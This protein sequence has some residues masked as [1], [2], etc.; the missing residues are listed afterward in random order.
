MDAVN[1]K[2]VKAQKRI[3]TAEASAWIVRLHGPYRTPELEEGFRAWLSAS[4]ENARQFERVT[5][6]WEAAAVPV[7]GTPRMSHDPDQFQPRRWLLAAAVALVAVGAGSWSANTLWL[8]P[9]YTT[10]IGEQRIFPLS[11]GS[12]VT[13]NSGSGVTVSYSR[14]ERRIFLD[15]GE[16]FFEVAKDSSRPF[17]VRAGKQQVEA[18]GT[19]FD[20]RREPHQV[21]VTLV[22]GK[23]AVSDLEKA[24]PG[25]TLSK[26]Q[27]LRIFNAHAAQVLD[28]PSIEAVTAWRMGEVMLDNT[29]L[30][31]AVSEMNRY[32][33]RSLVIDDPVISTVKI[34]GVY[35][36]GNSELF[37]NMLARLYGFDVQDRD[38]HIHLRSRSEPV[39]PEK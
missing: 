15:H 18:L 11:D 2:R 8:N 25:S 1:D 29:P 13:L 30:A 14:H 22:E 12:R 26:G 27:R 7:R 23:V 33:R 20:V 10:G 17:R 16:A 5:E 38:G 39:T 36:T 3:A 28:E 32:D 6:V 21:T 19:S 4:P 37:A 34:S 35:H 24:I 9:S 31:A